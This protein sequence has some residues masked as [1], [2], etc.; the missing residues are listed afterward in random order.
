MSERI[1]Q[2]LIWV[3]AIALILGT[4]VA[5]RYAGGYRQMAGLAP[6]PNLPPNISLRL[7]GVRA[8]GRHNHELAW[9]MKADQVDSTR[10]RTK[11]DFLGNIVMKMFTSNQERGTMTANTATYLSLNQMLTVSG[12]VVGTLRDPQMA[13]GE[14]FRLNTDVVH[15]N[16][17]ARHA[18]C[19]N[20][21]T[22]TLK[23][24]VIHGNQL[25]VDLK[26]RDHTMQNFEAELNIEGSESSLDPLGGILKE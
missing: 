8:S 20:A 18:I 19:P 24:G 9:N 2:I 13:R 12:N 5:L 22:I 26:T 25:D 15:W 10:D 14:A 7:K 6:P 4:G 1:Q 17:G 11:M 3:A 16:I 21:V 23:D